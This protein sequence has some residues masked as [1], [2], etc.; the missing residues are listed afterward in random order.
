MTSEEIGVY[1]EVELAEDLDVVSQGSGE[2]PWSIST[3]TR[4]SAKNKSKWVRDWDIPTGANVTG[5]IVSGDNRCDVCGLKGKPAILGPEQDDYGWYVICNPCISDRL[6]VNGEIPR[7]NP[8]TTG[9]LSGGGSGMGGT[10]TGHWGN[11]IKCPDGHYFLFTWPKREGFGS[12][13]LTSSRG[14]KGGFLDPQADLALFFDRWGWDFTIAAS[15]ELYPGS[16]GST[17]PDLGVLAMTPPIA[18][19]KWPDF[20][21]PTSTVKAYVEY[22]AECIAD[23]K[24]VQV[25]CMGGHGRTGTFA[26]LVMIAL[27]VGYTSALRTVRTKYC[28]EAIET[29][30]Q[31]AALPEF[32]KEVRAKVVDEVEGGNDD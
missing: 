4:L 16:D 22:A 15:V 27:G 14:I 1:S 29:K 6:S 20:T 21:E 5:S 11:A 26:A 25:G 3:T 28:Q 7:D 19:I 8:T 18:I 32:E 9:T 12:L 13:R 31:E 23:G 10:T 24:R 30:A 2:I 17:I